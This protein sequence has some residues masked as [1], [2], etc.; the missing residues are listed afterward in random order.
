MKLSPLTLI[1]L[2]CGICAGIVIGGS[3]LMYT[4]REVIVTNLIDPVI[5]PTITSPP[6]TPRISI[7]LP[8]RGT[9]VS[10]YKLIVYNGS[11]IPSEDIRIRNL[12]DGEGF[13]S[14][15]L[16]DIHESTFAATIIRYKASIPDAVRE[17]TEKAIR[18]RV[19]LAP[20]EQIPETHPYDILVIV[21]NQKP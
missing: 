20:A 14:M 3:Y 2:V 10:E 19:V 5:F 18:A 17:K 13:T 16:G 21:G 6:I 4:N 15:K 1:L 11:T 9:D 8:P 7:P 12:L